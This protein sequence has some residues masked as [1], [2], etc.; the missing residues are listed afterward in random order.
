VVVDGEM[1][2]EQMLER[3][4][5]VEIVDKEVAMEEVEHAVVE[6]QKKCYIVSCWFF[7]YLDIWISD[8]IVF[9]GV[10]KKWAI[11]ILEKLLALFTDKGKQVS[12]IQLWI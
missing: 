10:N 11:M 4:L 3:D 8:F 2:E 6:I 1:L 12:T 7:L 5:V 9:L